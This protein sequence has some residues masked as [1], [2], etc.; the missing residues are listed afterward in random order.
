VMNARLTLSRIDAC[1]SGRF[2]SSSASNNAS[3]AG[4]IHRRS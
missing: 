4:S 1:S 2:P 3:G